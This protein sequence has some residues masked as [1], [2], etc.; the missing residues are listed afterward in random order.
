MQRGESLHVWW[1]QKT[2]PFTSPSSSEPRGG[3]NR[4]LCAKAE[5]TFPG[6]SAGANVLQS[7]PVDSVLLS[8]LFQ[9]INLKSVDAIV[10]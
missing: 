1:L 9:L 2:T 10:D 3:I 4:F 8:E 6:L 7:V 5:V